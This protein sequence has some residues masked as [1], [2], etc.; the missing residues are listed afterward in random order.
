M[1]KVTITEIGSTLTN[2]AAAVIN[3][4]LK[5][6][7]D[8]VE[9]TLS[10]DGTGPNNLTADL[11]LDG[12]DILNVDNVHTEVLVLGGKVVTPSDLSQI[13]ATVMLKS[14]YDP[15]GREEEVMFPSVYDPEGKGIEVFDSDNIDF[16]QADANSVERSVEDKLS[17]YVDVEDFGAIGLSEAA[18]IAL[19]GNVAAFEAANDLAFARAFA[20]M[21]ARGGG[22][23]FANKS[24]FYNLS[25]RLKRPAGVY[26][27]GD[28][29]GEWEPIFP[30]RAKTWTGTTLLFRG[31]GTRDL[32]FDGITSQEH[33]GGWRE[34]PD[35]L[36]TYFK[37]FSGY[38][39]DA[40]G[41]TPATKKT[42]SAAVFV[43]ENTNYGGLAHLRIA[44]W[45]G[46]D[47]ISDW[48]NTGSTSLGADWD[49]GYLIRNG[50]YVDDYNIQV[51]GGWRVAAH[52]MVTTAISDSR[53]ER[54]RIVRAKFQ[55]KIGLLIAAPD[56]WAVTATTANSVTIRWTNQIYFNPTGGTFRGSDN[57]TYTYTGVT[58]AGS[59]AN[60]VFTGV[61]PDPAAAGIFH[62]RHAGAGYG[63]TEYQD[64]YS[65]GLEHQS[66]NKAPFFGLTDS[67]A[68]EASG[69]PLRGIKFRNSKFHTGEAVC[70][71]F[72]D[73]SDL[74]F[75]D[76]QF[77]GGKHVIASPVT[78]DQSYAAAPVADTR[79][80]VMI[81]GVG[82]ADCDLRLFL[83]RSGFIDE[84]QLAPRADLN[85]HA[86]M[87]PLRAGKDAYIQNYT[88]TAYVRAY[89]SGNVG[90]QA[91]GAGR[92]TFF[93]ASGNIG[94]GADNTQ[95]FGTNTARW[96][97]GYFTNIRPG[98]GGVI[99]TAGAG[100]PEAVVTAIV[101]S[102]YTDTTGG[103]LYVKAT[104]TGN[105]GWVV[106][107]TQT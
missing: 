93:G 67:K 37:K 40:T 14:V 26:V 100:T 23:I 30:N 98:A 64:V 44:N 68:L 31:T 74:I 60:Y 42:F 41:T 59:D 45:I 49:F 82:L 102:L 86:Y 28:N 36:G 46:T 13:P 83:P 3:E 53:A 78:T 1:A 87:K 106:A 24:Q 105:T 85:G 6:V 51:V 69:F 97:N 84:I 56:R 25:T 75:I 4:N 10:R 54:N 43:G 80:L 95:S 92:M 20:A 35:A 73:A 19:N 63:N 70:S 77:E 15:N 101:G 62:I 81:A 34:N 52:A 39:S 8:A 18:L 2:S 32:T 96:S 91:G 65:Y 27:I 29:V 11:D 104:G 71:H 103:K 7:Q 48:S 9:N 90:I 38:N 21:T 33:G 50:E 61:T 88:G 58:H 22:F 12:N 16:Q 89:D 72:H 5:R 94:A 66:G 57:V 76:P 55:G 79:N 47:G 107:G 17:Q 99:W